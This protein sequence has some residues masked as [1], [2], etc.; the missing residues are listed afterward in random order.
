MR[1]IKTTGKMEKPAILGGN[2]FGCVA[3][4][5][6]GIIVVVMT[7]AVGK[8]AGSA[9]AAIFCNLVA[10]GITAGVGVVG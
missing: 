2:M 8:V 4:P 6:E 7:G 3:V 1:N 5:K 10:A 9:V